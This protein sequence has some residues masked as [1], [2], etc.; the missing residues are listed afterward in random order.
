M[1]GI[2][3]KFELDSKQ[4]Q[5]AMR[6]L[7]QLDIGALVYNVGALIESSTQRR[8]Q[9]EKRSPEGEPWALR[10]PSYSQSRRPGQS[11][12][13]SDGDLLASIQNY[14]TGDVARVG[15]NMVYGAVHQLGSDGDQNIPA[16]P[17]LGL[18]ESD[19]TDINRLVIGE[20]SEL[21][22]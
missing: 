8:I 12:L 15:T 19:E 7:S 13:I 16:R 18:S 3:A 6:R 17:Y 21:L 22:H 2:A 1:V 10:S 14:S 11:I 20:V 4:A 5:L 9:E